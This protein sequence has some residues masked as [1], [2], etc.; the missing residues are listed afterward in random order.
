[1]RH[2]CIDYSTVVRIETNTMCIHIVRHNCIDYS[3]VVRIE[4]MSL[5]QYHMSSLGFKD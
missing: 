1:M 3:T 4:T 2:N 5:F